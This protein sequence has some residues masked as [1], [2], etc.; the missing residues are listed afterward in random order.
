[1]V[2][3]AV[4]PKFVVKGNKVIALLR[5]HREALFQPVLA[6]LLKRQPVDPKPAFGDQRDDINVGEPIFFF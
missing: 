6:N 1:V 4:Y 2:W 3:E 5:H